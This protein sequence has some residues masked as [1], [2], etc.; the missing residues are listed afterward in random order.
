MRPI[1]HG[2]LGDADSLSHRVLREFPG[3][4]E[5]GPGSIDQGSVVS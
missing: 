3:V 4:F 2:V 1:G 5:R